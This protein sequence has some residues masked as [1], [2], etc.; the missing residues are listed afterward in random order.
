M[1]KTKIF[2]FGFGQV[3]ESFINKLINEKKVFDLSVTSRQETHQIEFN[4]IKINS[5]QF[6]D[7]KYDNSIKKKIEEADYIL[8]SIPPI[9]GKDIVANYFDTNLKEIIN[10]K[11]ITYLSAT[12]V[13]GDHKG[14]WVNEDSAT[15]PTSENGVNRL[16]A[17]KNWKSLSNKKNFPLQIFRLAGIYSNKFNILKRLKTGKVQI[18]DKKNHFFSRIHVDDIANVLFKSLDNFKNNEI[19]N[20]CDDKPASQIEVAAYGAKLLKLEKPNSVKLE[21]LESEMLQNFYKDSKK[22]DNK[23]MKAFFKYDLKYPTYKEGLNY[24]FNNGL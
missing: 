20:I 16:K 2:C 4:H 13:Y 1:S 10:C 11:W 22:V 7:D 21:E 3:A 18:V 23:K 5:Y 15:Q 12:S 19:Y 8:V 9:N 24:I 14:D 6:T 17:E